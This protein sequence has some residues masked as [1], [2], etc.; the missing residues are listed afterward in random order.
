MRVER[1][2]MES[3]TI[4]R[5]EGDL[6][7]TGVDDLREAVYDCISHSRFNLVLNLRYVGFI[8]YMGVG[9]LVERLRKLRSFNGDIKLVG[10]NTYADRL[11]R[12]ASVHKLFDVYDEEARA[13]VVF[14]EAA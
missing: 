4:L 9:V 12:M 11:F 8:S 5:L 10:M 1:I 3:A 2:D 6:D 14:K 7:E 13:V